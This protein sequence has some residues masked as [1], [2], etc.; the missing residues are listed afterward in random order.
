MAKEKLLESYINTSASLI[1]Q[2]DG[3]VP[4]NNFLKE[5]F[6][7][8]KKF[9]SRDRKSITHL[10]YCYYRLGKSLTQ[11]P[12]KEKI[13][14]A[15]F[16]CSTKSNDLLSHFKSEWNEKV[17]YAIGEKISLLNIPFK[18]TEI[19]PWLNELSEKINASEFSMSHLAQPNLFLRIRPGKKEQVLKKLETNK[20]DFEACDEN[21]LSLPNT[22]KIEN[23]L[24]INK[25]IV[26]QDH[27]S[28]RIKEFFEVIKSETLNPKSKIRV[29]DCC[30]ASGGKSILATDILK[31]IDLTVSDIRP[32]IIHN[33]QKRFKE[34]GIKNYHSF[35]AD[36]TNSKSP[37]PNLKF[38][39][40]ICDAPCSGS[41]TWSRTPEQLY[42]FKEE[43]IDDYVQLQKKIVSNTIPHLSANGFFI[44]ITCSVF[45]KENEEVSGFIQNNFQLKLLTK[46][47]FIGYDK[48]A[49]TMFGA[50][51]RKSD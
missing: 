38:D 15:L 23:V 45:E 12:V 18:V 7:L 26:V 30:A 27:S 17:N 42:F 28:Q 20:I 31:N 41:G 1:Q 5:F 22:T 35:V 29:W 2:Y 50:L 48:K 51:F 33:L 32:S 37:I 40:I 24:D 6:S 25:E 9:G 8:H 46:K 11:I 44:Y 10:C 47:I 39:L 21:C 14:I 19:F 16:L 34:A 13:M 49:D 43:K 4:L 36:L 3:S